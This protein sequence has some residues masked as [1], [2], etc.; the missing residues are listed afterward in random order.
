MVLPSEGQK[1]TWEKVKTIENTFPITAVSMDR[2]GLFYAANEQGNI[3]KYDSTGALLFTY[4]P[5]K[6]SDITLLEA[7]RNVNIFVFN[8]SFQEFVF[9]D[10][11]MSPSTTN[12]IKSSTVG[13][14]RLATTSNDNN[15]WL[16]D[17]TDFSLKKYNLNSGNIDL[18]TPLD[19]VLDPSVY[20]MNFMRE[21]QNLVFLN[22]KNSGIF[23]FDNMANY[24]TKIPVKGLS[25]IGFYNDELYLQ[26]GDS[27]TFINIY[28]YAE[29]KE[30]LPELGNFQYIVYTASRLY[31]FNEKS[32][33]V[34]K[35]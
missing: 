15:L 9:L 21:Y 22:D 12:K 28:T 34:F 30:S 17:E 6:K 11:F 5:P 10:R 8:R 2:Y 4:S 14:A 31:L 26:E 16:I 35:R 13:F 24:K 23:I 32:I 19:L 29:R 18:S 25:M 3:Y 33:Y 20:E 7:W 1:L 27:L